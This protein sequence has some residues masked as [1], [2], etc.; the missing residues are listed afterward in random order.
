MYSGF[1]ASSESWSV[2]NPNEHVHNTFVEIRADAIR[3]SGVTMSDSDMFSAVTNVSRRSRSESPVS[4]SSAAPA[5]S[6]ASEAPSV[7]AV[8]EIEGSGVPHLQRLA[9]DS[10]GE[11]CGSGTMQRRAR[12]GPRERQRKKEKTPVGGAD[13]AFEAVP[14][15][16]GEGFAARLTRL[17]IVS[18]TSVSQYFEG[19]FEDNVGRI[20]YPRIMI[21]LIILISI[22]AIT[23]TNFSAKDA[24]VA[25]TDPSAT[26]IEHS[27]ILLNRRNGTDVASISAL[28]DKL[29]LKKMSIDFGTQELS[30][31]RAVVKELF[32]SGCSLPDNICKSMLK[33]MDLKV[34]KYHK[35]TSVP[36]DS[37][38]G[39][40]F[41]V[42]MWV[43]ETDNDDE[44]QVAYKAGSLS[45]HLRDVV[46]YKDKVEEDPVYE[47][48]TKMYMFSS[49]RTCRSMGTK[50]TVT[51]MP[52]FTQTIMSPDE[53]QLVD[54]MMEGM[55]AKK[56]IEN[57]DAANKLSGR[58][59][60]SYHIEA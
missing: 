44:V 27:V 51:S 52:V 18:C 20:P 46:T 22:F 26:M 40:Y 13:K 33:A 45:Y 36:L 28:Q 58:V 35:K 30:G 41:G 55:L 16:L 25:I 14:E 24:V 39:S 4:K 49:E 8:K 3:T 50:K 19:I 56:V 38:T 54:T 47:C 29:Q 6:H 60:S 59:S 31:S 9:A 12:P 5:L 21:T 53:M 15:D 48:E 37:N 57:A 2:V 23:H 17:I 7:S 43:Q 42:W 11:P 10:E 1:A 32:S 34:A